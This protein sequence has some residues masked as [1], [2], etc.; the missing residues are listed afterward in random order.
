VILLIILLEILDVLLMFMVKHQK[1]E[2]QQLW[3]SPLKNMFWVVHKV[4]PMMIN[5]NVL[6]DLREDN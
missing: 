1:K 6:M 3:W 4:L 2:L 5:G